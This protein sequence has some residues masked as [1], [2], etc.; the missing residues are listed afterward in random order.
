[1]KNLM[2]IFCLYFLSA[3][4][5]DPL[6][7][8]KSTWKENIDGFYKFRESMANDLTENHLEKGMTYQE[9]TYLIG[10]PDNIANL[11]ENT[12][13]YTLMEDYGW[14]ID[15]VEIKT[16]IIGLTVDSLVQEVN[17]THWK[18]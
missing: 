14:D 3:C 15:P 9:L 1:M 5:N 13:G 2:V 8:E 17:V 16:L 7:F 10:E 6:D 12:I 18:K 11:M 4:G